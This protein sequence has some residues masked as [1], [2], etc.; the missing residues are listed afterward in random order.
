MFQVEALDSYQK[1]WMMPPTSVRNREPFGAP[2]FA[3]PLSRVPRY[4]AC[5][6]TCGVQ[7]MGIQFQYPILWMLAKH[8]TPAY[9]VPN[10]WWNEVLLLEGFNVPGTEMAKKYDLAQL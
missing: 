1:R 6:Q 4:V 2:N 5:I 10:D 7:W 8:Y 9:N 3:R